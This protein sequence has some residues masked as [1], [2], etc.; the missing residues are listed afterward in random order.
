[1]EEVERANGFGHRLPCSMVIT[2]A[3]FHLFAATEAE[4]CVLE[5]GLGGRGD[6]TNA[7]PPPAACAITSISLDH[8]ELLGPTLDAIAREKAG[9]MKSGVPLATGTQPDEVIAVLEAEAARTGARLLQRGRDWSIER[10][11][12]G[13]RFND[14]AGEIDLP[15]PSLAGPHQF[16]NAAIAIAAL[17]AAGLGVA[18]A[19]IARGIAA[20][21][22]PGRLQRL[23]GRLAERLPQDWELWLDGG[24]NPGG[25]VALAG[26]SGGLARPA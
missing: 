14:A 23:T 5:V 10:N 3:A 16:D 24:H 11:S 8:R 20:A 25:G 17:R 21:E 9:I 2:A 19:A 22:W 13:F 12:T 15:P 6:T 4:L 26:A 1:M 7:I 18:N